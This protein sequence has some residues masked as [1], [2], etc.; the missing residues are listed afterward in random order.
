MY[1]RGTCG[2]IYTI[3][4]AIVFKFNHGQDSFASMLPK[5]WQG[6]QEAVIRH[7]ESM[8]ERNYITINVVQD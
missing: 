6:T 4:V 5:Y 1:D 3:E 7:D 8:V 2:H